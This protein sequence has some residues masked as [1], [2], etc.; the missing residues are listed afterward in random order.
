MQAPTNYLIPSKQTGLIT[1]EEGKIVELKYQSLQ[2]GKVP[3]EQLP[4]IIKGLLLK[5]HAITGWTVP[6]KELQKIL[7]E[8]FILK[9]RESYADLNPDEIL[10]AFRNNSE[11]KDWGKKMN[12]SLFDEV[13]IP[14]KNR[15]F[16]LSHMEERV[17]VGSNVKALPPSQVSDDD[18]INSIRQ[19]WILN[20]KN[21]KSIPELAYTTL[22][23]KLDLTEDQK[24]EY[25]KQVREITGA[26]GEE[27][28][29]RCRQFVVHQYFLNNE[30]K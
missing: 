12:L 27:F 11:V 4:V 2:L 24:T 10:Y 29:T 16:E 30:P 21:F 7:L 23:Q 1:P 17:K 26:T 18:F 22:L 8:Q 13:L 14:Y 6:E 5:I 19:L 25:K 3:P 15:R 9:A 28:K 20:N